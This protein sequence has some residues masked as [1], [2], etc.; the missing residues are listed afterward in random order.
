MG[1]RLTGE[2][3]ICGLTC[4]HL[5]V[6]T[7]MCPRCIVDPLAARARHKRFMVQT[8]WMWAVLLCVIAA[9]CI[10]A[11]R[12]LPKRSVSWDYDRSTIIFIPVP[13]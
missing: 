1:V 11:E 10:L 6:E 12:Y 2:C 4:H 9:L 3:S 5:D 8:M 13:L 7:A